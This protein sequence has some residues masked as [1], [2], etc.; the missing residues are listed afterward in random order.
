MKEKLYG[1]VLEQ[2][3]LSIR[4]NIPFFSSHRPKIGRDSQV[5]ETAQTP[6]WTDG[7]WSGEL[8]LAYSQT[9]DTIF[10]DAG[11]EQLT[12]FEGGL[13]GRLPGW[14]E[15]TGHDL[16]FLF[17]LSA[18]P[19]YRLT[20]NRPA[21]EAAFKAAYLLAERFRESYQ[22]IQAWDPWWEHDTI[23]PGRIIID[24]MENIPLLNWAS[25]ENNDPGLAAIAT[26]HAEISAKYLVRADGSISHCFDFDPQTGQPWHESTHQGFSEH[27]A[28]AR[29]EAWAIHGF[30]L[31]YAYTHDLRFLKLAR[32]VADYVIKNLPDDHVPFWDYRL[33]DTT[34]HYKDSSAAAISSAGLLLLTDL[35]GTSEEATTYSDAA[36]A[37]LN[38]LIQNYRAPE[39]SQGLLL[40]GASNVN[41]FLRSG[42][43]QHADAMLPYGD[44]FFVEALL[45]A[46]HRNV[47]VWQ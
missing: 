13:E 46:L 5:Y 11:L 44:Y 2:S 14:K 19:A 21:K 45:R 47:T 37:I 16:G 38:S 41:E 34:P 27:S 1:K 12:Y 24:S 23:N 31:F 26:K 22:A 7:F 17:M 32:R 36:Y 4:R 35:M 25:R 42:S 18:V 15:R 10:R 40:H 29:G 39:D 9:S 43:T 30:S 6:F 3:F 33:P 28:W 8:W 20:H